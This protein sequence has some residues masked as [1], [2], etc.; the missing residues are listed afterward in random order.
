MTFDKKTK[1]EKEFFS[2]W[3]SKTINVKRQSHEMISFN[4]K[5]LV[6]HKQKHSRVFLTW[7]Y[8]FIVDLSLF[9]STYHFQ[10]DSFVFFLSSTMKSTW[11]YVRRWWWS[12]QSASTNKLLGR[13]G[14]GL[15]LWI[16]IDWIKTTFHVK[17]MFVWWILCG[18]N[19]PISNENDRG[20][21]TTSLLP[22]CDVLKSSICSFTSAHFTSATRTS[23]DQIRWIFEENHRSRWSTRKV[24][25]HTN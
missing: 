22:F 2:I 10:I 16:K 3:S 11:E 5:L 19:A 7:R 25:L 8:Q 12:N 13:D 20:L 1:K 24:F 14:F 15:T 9:D 6:V 23:Q 18:N 21:T 4:E 17:Q